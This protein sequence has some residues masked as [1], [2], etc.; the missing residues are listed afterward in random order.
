MVKCFFQIDRQCAVDGSTYD[1]RLFGAIEVR[2]SLGYSIFISTI[3]RNRKMRQFSFIVLLLSVE[4]S[5][6][7]FV[8]QFH[9]L[10]INFILVTVLQLQT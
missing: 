1:R 7:S 2:V 10:I 3:L 8:S 9:K 4:K 5:G 6:N